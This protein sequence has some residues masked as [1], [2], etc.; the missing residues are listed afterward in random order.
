MC[1]VVAFTIFE[2]PES[3]SHSESLGCT[4]HTII[5]KKIQ[6]EATTTREGRNTSSTK[7]FPKKSFSRAKSVASKQ[8]ELTFAEIGPDL[9]QSSRFFVPGNTVVRFPPSSF[10]DLQH[11]AVFS[12]FVH[13]RSRMAALI[14]NDILQSQCSCCSPKLFRESFVSVLEDLLGGTAGRQDCS[15]FGDPGVDLVFQV[16]RVVVA[17]RFARHASL[18]WVEEQ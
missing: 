7:C 5:R 2:V 15:H 3:G 13:R 18:N 8:G 12:R 11:C 16:D 1:H 4:A 10:S 9:C 6:E 14:R 17:F